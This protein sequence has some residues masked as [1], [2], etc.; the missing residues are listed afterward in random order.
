[1]L[2]NSRNII[3]FLAKISPSAFNLIEPVRICFACIYQLFQ[4]KISA[5]FQ[6][7][8]I[9]A[10]YFCNMLHFSL[11]ACLFLPNIHPQR[12][13]CKRFLQ[14]VALFSSKFASQRQAPSKTQKP[15]EQGKPASGAIM[16]NFILLS[17]PGRTSS[18]N[19]T[20]LHG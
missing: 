14:H 10:R 5:Y 15:P 7:L 3:L 1:M 11:L 20:G 2:N 4:I 16:I 13:F 12:H 6:Q 19:G 8:T 18:D 9:S 17:V